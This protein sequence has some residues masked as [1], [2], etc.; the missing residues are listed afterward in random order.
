[1][2]VYLVESIKGE[3]RHRRNFCVPSLLVCLSIL[4]LLGDGGKKKQRRECAVDL[5]SA[6]RMSSKER[7]LE[8]L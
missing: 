6:N 1:M 7:W 8:R 4:L 5:T 2:I 3:I